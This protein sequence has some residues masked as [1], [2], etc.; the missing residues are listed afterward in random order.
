MARDAQRSPLAMVSGPAPVLASPAGERVESRM[1]DLL[2]GL[3]AGGGGIRALVL[4]PERGPLASARRPWTHR[5]APGT[6]GM[7]IDLDLDATWHAIVTATRDAVVRAGVAPE[8]I[9]GVAASA[10]RFATVVIAGDGAPLFAAPNRDGR[11]AGAC[12]ELLAEGAALHARTGHGPTP[13]SLLARLRWLARQEGAARAGHALALSDWIAWR[14]CGALATDRSQ[15]STSGL[16]DLA[17]GVWAEDL[18]D[19][20]GIPRAWLPPIVPAGSRLGALGAEAARA[21]GLRAGIA[22]AAG[23]ADTQCALLGAGAIEAGAAGVVAGTSAPVQ[24]VCA[25]PLVDPEARA[26]TQCHVAPERW[27]VESNAGPI[28]EALEWTAG[29]LFADAPQPVARLFAEAAQA[30]PGAGGALACFGAPVSDP[31]G[32]GIPVA[33]LAFSPLVAARDPE[34][35]RLA[36]RAFVEGA[37]FAVRANLALAAGVAGA[38]PAAVHA[39]GG[40]TASV[41]FLGVLADVLGA[42]VRVGPTSEASALGAALCAGVGAGAFADLADAVRRGAPGRIAA[43]PDPARAADADRH[44]EVWLRH[45]E[46]RAPADA[47]AGERL[48]PEL[49]RERAAA[50]AAG[51]PAVAPRILATADLDAASLEALR[52]LGPVEHAPFREA[53][54][55]LSGPALVEAL[56]GVAVFVTEVDVLDAAALARLPALRV[57]AACR[58]DAVNVDVEACTAYGIPVLYAPGRN[59][60]AVADLTVAFALALLR[61]LPEA[62]AFLR[63]P[64]IAAGDMGRMG[65][66]FSQLR[67]R[68]LGGKTVGLVGLGAVGRAVARRLRGFGARVVVHDPFVPPEAAARADAEWLALDELLAASDVVSLH[69]PVTDATRGLLDAARLARMKPGAFLINTARAALVDEDAL[70][71][72]LRE[73]RLAGAALDVFA[74][75][76]PGAD[77]PLLQLPNVIATPHVGGNTH[78]V[79]AHQGRI[80]AADLARLLRGERPHHVL[81][82]EALSR[83]TWDAERPAPDPAR[84]ASLSGRPGPAVSDLQRDARAGAGTDAGAATPVAEAALPAGTRGVREKMEQLLASFVARTLADA[85]LARFAGDRDVTLHFT[86]TDLALDFWLRLRAGLSGALGAP[87]GRPEVDL[88]LRAD[89]LDGMFTGRVNPMQ[90]A[91]QGRLSFTGDA[92]KAMTLQQIQPALSRHWCAARDEVGDPGDLAALPAPGSGAGAA[93]AA[94]PPADALRSELVQVVRELYA[95]E[96]ITATGGNVSARIPGRDELWI[97]PSQLFKGDLRPEILVRI[98]LDGATLETQGAAPSSERL[99]HCAVYRARPDAQAVVHAHAPHATILANAGL[100]FLPISTEAAFF[101]EL[102]R[103]PF[104]MPGTDALAQAVEE[105]ARESWAVLMVNHGLLVAGRSLRRAADMTE[106][107]ERSAQVILGCHALGREPPVL[108]PAVVAE[109]RALGDLVA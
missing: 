89:V 24:L 23:G 20:S 9:A 105:A 44:Y 104:I 29:L 13:I 98:G 31:R 66:A 52:A 93:A 54:R 27:V 100:P 109:L 49:L 32:L 35:R 38:A 42:P 91:M 73:G 85:E 47:P 8:A 22:V 83:F 64:G 45:A 21:L 48:L 59:A 70:A 39:G 72:A 26:W 37:A 55:L 94:A 96:L 78:E 107:V 10:M 63:Q 3:D 40:M 16:F 6:A 17:R 12:F 5:A 68:E 75:E 19:A 53:M 57:V 82:P 86:L 4:D 71:A 106:I 14:L 15:A 80:V 67:G 77:H 97:T 61:K 56:D 25:R 102:P 18:A 58:G 87:A 28:G 99:M 90:A 88:K 95:Q 74:V 92:A 46:A 103:V 41:S 69:A 7:G 33:S 30:P 1:A 2:L 62:Q 36:A 43:Q 65:Q 108:P 76:P 50:G 34:R 51:A 84:L 101:G 11:A 60:E 81:D 79:G